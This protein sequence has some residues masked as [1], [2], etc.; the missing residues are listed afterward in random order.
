MKARRDHGEHNI[1]KVGNRWHCRVSLGIHPITGKRMRK[2]FTGA[3][4]VEA[5]ELADAYRKQFEKGIDL[6]SADTPVAEFLSQWLE[7]YLS[8]RDLRAS[9][10][11]RYGEQLDKVSD[12]IGD[13]PMKSVTP[14]HLDLV[15][16]K[17]KHLVSLHKSYKLLKA[18][19][20]DA[21]KYDIIEVSPFWKH[22]P[23]RPPKKTEVS[24][25]SKSELQLLVPALEGHWIEDMIQFGLET[26]CR[27]GEMIGLSWD[28][29]EHDG[30]NSITI[31]RSLRTNLGDPIVSPPKTQKGRR[32]IELSPEMMVRLAK[33]REKNEARALLEGWT[34][35]SLIFPSRAGSYHFASNILKEFK[36]VCKAA[37]ITQK[38]NLHQLRHTNA[39][40]LIA[41]GID[42][43]TLSRRLGHET[44][45][46]TSDLYGHLIVGQQRDAAAAFGN[47]LKE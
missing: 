8:K 14:S 22:D 19:F 17:Q 33:K 20:R 27:I 47:F 29:L 44:I 36:K 43:H 42:L 24:F 26:G 2:L 35:N 38:V 31:R 13:V 45:S 39:T 30:P 32:V 16:K 23:P 11:K 37:G 28:D 7:T 6:E 15:V 25:L 40:I 18:A 3:T 9:T 12:I 5:R 46:V 4:R 21:V 10:I 34:E 41:A 1:K